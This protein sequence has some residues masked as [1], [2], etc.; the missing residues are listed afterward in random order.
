MFDAGSPRVRQRRRARLR[1]GLARF[2]E[3]TITTIHGFCQQALAQS[4]LRAGRSGAAELVESDREVI[5]EVVRDLLLDRLADDPY[6]LSPDRSGRPLGP[7]SFGAAAAKARRPLEPA[8]VERYIVAAVSAVLSNPEPAASRHRRSAGW[9]APGRTASPLL[10]PRSSGA[11]G[12]GAR[13]ATTASSATSLPPS[14]DPRHGVQLATQLPPGTAWSSSTSSRT[15]TVA[16]GDLRARLRRSPADHRRRPEAGDL[17]FPRC[18]RAR[19]SRR[20][21]Q[22]ITRDVADEPPLG[23]AT[24][25]RH[26]RAVRRRPP[27]PCRHR[28]LPRRCQPGRSHQRPRRDRRPPARRPRRSEH[29]P[30]HAGDGGGS[31]G[32]SR[33]HRCRLPGAHAARHGPHRVGSPRPPGAALRHRHPRAVAAAGHGGGRRAA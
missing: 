18:R 29:R 3:A 11:S 2:D 16:V 8:T 12:R 26:R 25:R 33:A 7:E 23:P 22:R 24:A 21:A 17:P 4:G 19:V 28:V 15:P 32:E 10:S 20:R 31:R 13:S 1:R 9:P 6:A 5:A 27:R 30:H 14:T